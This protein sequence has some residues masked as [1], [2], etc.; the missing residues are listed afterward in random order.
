MESSEQRDPAH[1]LY[2][3]VLRLEDGVPIDQS[4][5]TFLPHRRLALAFGPVKVSPLADGWLDISSPVFC[6]A[7]HCEDH[8]RE[9]LSD[10][11]FDLLPGIPVRIRA[12]GGVKAEQ[13]AFEAVIGEAI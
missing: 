3:A 6:H 10:N 12:A 1:W 13:L 8:G 9:L 4:I 2:A 7:V 11:W 5:W